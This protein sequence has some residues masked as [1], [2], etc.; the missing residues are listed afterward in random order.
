MLSI[1]PGSVQNIYAKR[2]TGRRASLPLPNLYTSTITWFYADFNIS[3]T[4]K[5]HF[6]FGCHANVNSQYSCNF[7]ENEA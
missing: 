2:Y 7:K 5:V 4:G 1:P 6:R 3:E